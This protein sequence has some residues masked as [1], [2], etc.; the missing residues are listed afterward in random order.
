[1]SRA[2]RAQKR[3]D[4]KVTPWDKTVGRL[5]LGLG[6]VNLNVTAVEVFSVHARDGSGAFVSFAESDEGETTRAA[7]LTIHSDINI[8]DVAELAEGVTE[9][10]FGGVERKITNIEF[11]VHRML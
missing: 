5:D 1:M 6:F 11:G 2:F 8:G 4:I 3:G 7:R 10:V 9:A